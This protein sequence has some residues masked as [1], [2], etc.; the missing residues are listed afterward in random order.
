MTAR[1]MQRR[2]GAMFDHGLH[3]TYHRGG[4]L[5]TEVVTSEQLAD[6]IDLQPL[7]KALEDLPGL[8]VLRV[9]DDEADIVR[10]AQPRPFG[11]S[12]LKGDLPEGV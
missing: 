4:S 1:S 12:V 10:H 2:D 3:F 7:L 9:M 6:R 8:M 5:T 11:A